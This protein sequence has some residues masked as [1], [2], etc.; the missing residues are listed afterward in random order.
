MA[1]KGDLEIDALIRQNRAFAVYRLPGEKR[2][3]F[4]GQSD[5]A[6][7]IIPAI[8]S[9]NGQNGFVIAP[10]NASESCPVLLIK[11][12]EEFILEVPDII[13]SN[14]KKES[15]R[16]EPPANYQSKFV[17]FTKA[18]ADNTFEKLVLSHCVTIPV[19]SGF[20]PSNIFYRA[21]KRYIR[22]YVY[23]FH[24]PQT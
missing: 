17:E 16:Q 1:V 23:L 6:V 22:S 24:T 20:S 13:V 10:F 2:F 19:K 9:L 11:P 14:R 3:H 15:M 18:L 7:R 4:I 5:N 8:E 21:C 12:D